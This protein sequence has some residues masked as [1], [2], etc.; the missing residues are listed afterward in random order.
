MTLHNIETHH[1]NALTP[2][3]SSNST[4]LKRMPARLELFSKAV[5]SRGQNLHKILNDAESKQAAIPRL[6]LHLNNIKPN[7]KKVIRY[8]RACNFRLEGQAL[9][10]TYPHILAF[11]LH[12]KVMTHKRFPLPVMGLVHI[13]N[14]ITSYRTVLMD[15][16]LDLHVFIGESRV[17]NKGL[18]FDIH[19]KVRINNET[20]WES[21]TTNLYIIKTAAKRTDK[22]VKDLLRSHETQS[23]LRY[24][25]QWSLPENLGRK[26]ALASGDANP[27]HLHTQLAKTFGFKHSIT[28]GMWLKAHT[29]ASL[30][31]IIKSQ[32][33]ITISV[34]FKQQTPLNNKVRMNYQEKPVP[35]STN[36]NSSSSGIDFDI[37]SMDGRKLHMLGFIIYP[38]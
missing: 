35:A 28:H 26:Y 34:E 18:E 2:L 17:T 20:V 27:I 36:L 33:A 15:E 7:H 5:L 22:E 16:S 24:H 11:N 38:S 31:P 13:R 14:T 32:L 29:I 10:V 21:I 4:L 12:L 37:R 9:P 19:S 30:A 23:S 8:A 1:S 6:S 3:H 25:Q